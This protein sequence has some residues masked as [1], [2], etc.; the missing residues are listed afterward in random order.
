[1]LQEPHKYRVHL[2]YDACTATDDGQSTKPQDQQSNQHRTEQVETSRVVPQEEFREG[3]PAL[4]LD[5][6]FERAQR[7]AARHTHTFDSD[8][9][10][11]LQVASNS[12]N[13]RLASLSQN[14]VICS[15]PLQAVAS[16]RSCGA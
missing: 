16:L 7:Y 1:M 2:A 12:I 15:M 13:K 14:C 8:R 6:A 5:E 10:D 9:H 3:L 4:V 11:L